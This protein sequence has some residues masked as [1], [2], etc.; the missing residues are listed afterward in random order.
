MNKIDD[1]IERFFNN[2]SYHYSGFICQICKPLL[3]NLFFRNYD[4]KFK[5]KVTSKFY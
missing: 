5:I 4:N 1:M 3:K 2:I